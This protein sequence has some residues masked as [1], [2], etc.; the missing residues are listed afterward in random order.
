MQLKDDELVDN[1]VFNNLLKIVFFKT[2]NSRKSN[3][4]V[5]QL[6]FI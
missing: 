2:E 1:D 5:I 3:I 4:I 6:H